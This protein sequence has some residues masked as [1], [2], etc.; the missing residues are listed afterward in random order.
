M[1]GRSTFVPAIFPLVC[2]FGPA[3]RGTSGSPVSRLRRRSRHPGG[4]GV[5]VLLGGAGRLCCSVPGRRQRR[6]AARRLAVHRTVAVGGLAH[7]VPGVAGGRGRALAGSVEPIRRSVGSRRHDV[8]DDPGRGRRRGPDGRRRSQR[9]W[10]VA[11]GHRWCRHECPD[12]GHRPGCSARRPVRDRGDRAWRDAP[13]RADAMGGARLRRNAR[14]RGADLVLPPPVQP[15]L[16]RRPRPDDRVLRGGAGGDPCRVR[17]AQASTRAGGGS[18][19]LDV[20][21]HRGAARSSVHPS[22]PHDRRSPAAGGRRA[23]GGDEPGCPGPAGSECRPAAR[24]GRH[25]PRLDGA[26]AGRDPVAA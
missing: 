19:P 25:A 11:G 14:R 26:A 15:W 7:R 12:A 21:P 3:V 18:A 4:L 10:L 8:D 1:G 6:R 20:G 24:P 17:S 13:V 9:P 23:R 5:R 16:V 22:R 2:R